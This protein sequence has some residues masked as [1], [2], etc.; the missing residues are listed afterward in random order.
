MLTILPSTLIIGMTFSSSYEISMSTGLVTTIGRVNGCCLVCLRIWPRNFRAVTLIIKKPVSNDSF[1]H[2]AH[3]ITT[4]SDKGLIVKDTF[5]F[6]ILHAHLSAIF[7]SGCNCCCT[8]N[9]ISIFLDSLI[10]KES[11]FV[12]LKWF[13]SNQINGFLSNQ[14]LRV[15]DMRTCLGH[16]SF[17]TE[18]ASRRS[19]IF[20]LRLA[21]SGTSNPIVIRSSKF[22]SIRSFTSIFNM[23]ANNLF[24]CS[25]NNFVDNWWSGGDFISTS[26]W[27]FYMVTKCY[28]NLNKCQNDLTILTGPYTLSP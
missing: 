7:P 17:F 2:G 20:I 8:N 6:G 28:Q 4:S 3:S 16:T 27:S 1:K 25:M 26:I 10:E 12:F 23:M 15:L 5:T 21:T 11:A 18:I 24:H 14:T 19:G 9:L 13:S 22:D